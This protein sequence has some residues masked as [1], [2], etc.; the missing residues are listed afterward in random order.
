M[1]QKLLSVS[2]AIALLTLSSIPS[3]LA[4]ELE[5]IIQRG[6]LI[7]GVKDNLRPL[8]FSDAQ[9][10]LQGLEIDI[11]KRLAEEL[12]R[13][14]DAVVLQPVTN[15]ERL[16]VVIEGKVDL[17]IA[18]VTFTD[19][20]F[21]IVDLS[22][23]YYLDGTGLVTKNLAVQQLADLTS[24]KIAVLK[25][26][27]TISVVHYQLPKAQLIGVESYQEALS[28]LESGQA[29][30]FA[31]DNSVLTGWVQEYPQYRMLPVRLSGEAL[32]IVMPKGLQYADLSARVNAA[33]AHWQKSGW[34]QERATYWGLP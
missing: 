31:A 25:D 23:Y 2:L 5:E 15:Q 21:R 32:C 29:D 10:N 16:Q 18:R 26:S 28:L 34:L 6:K 7:V 20:R 9:G 30:A 1:K 22:N 12:L 19:S 4:A 14:P 24:G 27:S 8:G 13:N 17:T 3:T 11:A 33:I